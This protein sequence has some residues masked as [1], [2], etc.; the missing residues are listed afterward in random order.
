MN[1]AAVAREMQGRLE[2]LD[3][4]VAT[5]LGQYTGSVT[6]PCV[7]IPLPDVNFNQTYARGLTR[8]PE[9]EIAVLTGKPD[10]QTG[11][12]RAGVYADGTGDSSVIAALQSGTYTACDTVTVVRVIF[13][14]ITWQGQ[15]FQGALFTVDVAGR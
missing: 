5:Y 9:W 13:D 2:D 11:F 3:G 15:D 1:L 14:L 12:D 8:V 7:V 10:D 6:P 4:I